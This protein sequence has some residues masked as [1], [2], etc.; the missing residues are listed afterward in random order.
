VI[1]G[2]GAGKSTLIN[3]L[4]QEAGMP[5]RMA[6]GTNLESCTGDIIPTVV[7]KTPN[8]ALNNALGNRRL[9]L[10]DTPGFDD[11]EK[12]DE[13]I[14]RLISTW[15]EGS[16]RKDMLVGGVLYLHDITRDGWGGSSKNN[17]TLFSK[18]CG[19]PAMSQVWFVTTKWGKLKDIGDGVKRLSQLK[20][21]FW[22]SMIG[23]GASVC[24]LQHTDS[25]EIAIEG[26]REPWNIIH[27][28]V[29]SMNGRNVLLIQEELVKKKM[30]LWETRAGRELREK[31]ERLLE[32]TKNLRKETKAQSNQ[33]AYAKDALDRQQQKIDQLTGQ[34]V[35]LRPSIA[36]RFRRWIRGTFTK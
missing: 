24:N 7:T 34:L 36:E 10:V 31:L 33:A 11:T 2:N 9:V 26:Q 17:L 20:E 4:L 28:L 6:V 5:D 25:L 14:L 19:E 8:E 27:E 21:R 18:L 30:L 32:D 23:L 22:A 16:Y 29:V 35:R 3:R 12:D 1:G 13:Q 15:L